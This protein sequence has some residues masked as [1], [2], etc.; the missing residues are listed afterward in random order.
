M[1][2]SILNSHLARWLV[3]GRV[4]KNEVKLR[5][6]NVTS[7]KPETPYV[8]RPEKKRSGL[9]HSLPACSPLS[10]RTWSTQDVASVT[11]SIIGTSLH[12]W[13]HHT[14]L[15]LRD[16]HSWPCQ[17][18]RSVHSGNTCVLWEEDFSHKNPSHLHH[19]SE[20]LQNESDSFLFPHFEHSTIFTYGVSSVA[21][22]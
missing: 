13:H 15:N 6:R 21:K 12:I 20:A 11:L 14:D 7:F 19:T 17:N 22:N 5:L 9:D 18:A 2:V 16:K 10:S 1:W 4:R 3:I 8:K